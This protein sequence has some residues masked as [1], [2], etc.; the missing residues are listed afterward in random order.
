MPEPCRLTRHEE[1]EASVAE[2]RI[3]RAAGLEEADIADRMC[4]S[5]ATVHDYLKP[6]ALT[7]TPL[8][9]RRYQARRNAAK[10]ALTAEHDG[11]DHG[12]ED[13]RR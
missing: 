4:K 13:T 3:M 6:G 9:W 5:V 1:Y 8:R 7:T 2:A 12:P 11:D 10:L